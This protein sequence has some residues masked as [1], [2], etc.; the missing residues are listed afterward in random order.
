M[1]IRG[2][3]VDKGYPVCEAASKLYSILSNAHM[4]RQLRMQQPA[5]TLLV[6]IG[7]TKQVGFITDKGRLSVLQEKMAVEERA[8]KQEQYL[9]Q[10]RHTQTWSNLAGVSAKDGF[11]GGYTT[12]SS[13]S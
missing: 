5:G 1:K 4:L 10:Q 8:W 12:S 7:S 2:G 13:S 9:E 6:P 3:S 11:G